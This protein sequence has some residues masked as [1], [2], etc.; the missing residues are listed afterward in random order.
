MRVNLLK[1][2]H[3]LRP[4]AD[5]GVGGRIEVAVAAFFRG[6]HHNGVAAVALN[7]RMIPGIDPIA[8]NECGSKLTG[9]REE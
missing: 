2:P 4:R 8:Q 7:M 1:A 9:A 6:I 3:P 5:R